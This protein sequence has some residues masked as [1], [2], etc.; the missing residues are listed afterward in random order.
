MANEITKNPIQYLDL[1]GLQLFWNNAREFILS[2][3]SI[4]T[5]GRAGQT[6]ASGAGVNWRP[7]NNEWITVVPSQDTAGT[8]TYTVNDG[9]ITS[10]FGLVENEL[11]IV[12]ANAGVTGVK[13]VDDETS[14]LV[15]VTVTNSLPDGASD[16]QDG[17][18]KGDITITL[19]ETGLK[20][21]ET[22]TKANEK[23]I[24]DAR[25]ADIKAIYG[26]GYTDPAEGLGTSGTPAK[27]TYGDITKIN[28]RLVGIDASLVTK[29]TTID[30]NEGDVNYV[31]FTS[32]AGTDGTGAIVLTVDEKEL[33]KKIV[34]IDAAIS[35]ET[36]ARKSKDA[37]LAGNGWDEETAV[38]TSAPAYA[39]IASLSTQMKTAEGKIDALS[40]AT[41]F[42]G[43]FADQN[44][45][46]AAIKD[47]G[48]IF[49]IGNK[50]YIYNSEII[51]AVWDNV[52]E[53]GD[54]TEEVRRISALEAHVNAYTVITD[55]EINAIF[56]KTVTE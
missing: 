41:H 8:T 1:A 13:F 38:W 23:S 3:K 44:T 27:M 22:T 53:L 50:E 2:N 12:K 32:S 37:L 28:Q 36:A 5:A 26:T 46:L 35:T 54:T 55:A 14:N 21:F 6:V 49:I 40:S 47:F 42:I 56:G 43:V 39:T 4:V 31:N 7:D 34:S 19:D 33:D 15:K 48:D 11:A 51:P 45:A 10:K 18:K 25:K 24:D 29:V 52:V 16:G 20:T 17:M 9:N 30:T